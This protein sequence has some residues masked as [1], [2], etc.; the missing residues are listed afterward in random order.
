[1][2][3]TFTSLNVRGQNAEKIMVTC[4]K[5]LKRGSLHM[6]PTADFSFFLKFQDQVFDFGQGFVCPKNFPVGFFSRNSEKRT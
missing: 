2:Q 3:H 5:K 1:M 4:L 6:A